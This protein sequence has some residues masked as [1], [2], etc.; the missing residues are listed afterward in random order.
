VVLNCAHHVGHPVQLAHYKINLILT[1]PHHIL[2]AS[3]FFCKFLFLFLCYFGLPQNVLFLKY[4]IS[5]LYSFDVDLESFLLEDYRKLF[6]FCRLS[7]LELP[8]LDRDLRVKLNIVVSKN[9][10]SSINDSSH[11]GTHFKFA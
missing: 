8:F 6:L 9:A 11:L 2:N 10:I 1:S 7:F 5:H 3:I 4:T